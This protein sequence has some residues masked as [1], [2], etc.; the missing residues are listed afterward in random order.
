MATSRYFE[1]KLSVIWT[2]SLVSWKSKYRELTVRKYN[3]IIR[4][5]LLAD[6]TICS[7]CRCPSGTDGKQ[8][9][10]APE[11]CIGDPCMHGG[12]CQDFG[13]G[14]NCS[15]P[16]GFTG[17]G[18]QYEYDTCAAQGCLNGATCVDAGPQFTCV[19]PPGFTG[20]NCEQDIVDC[21]E[22]S[23]PPSATCIDLTDRFYC[24]CPF[25]LTGEDCRKSE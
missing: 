23:C 8:C 25:N 22:N 18:C 10:T 14:L 20:R 11:R 5:H 24:Q 19:C 1:F 4:F 6:I 12:K 21:Q 7:I 2:F 17:V 9:E 13:S 16:S 15:C 3:L